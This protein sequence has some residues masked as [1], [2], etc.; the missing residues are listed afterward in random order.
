MTSGDQSAEG[1]RSLF[2]L[3]PG[4]RD[5]LIQIAQSLGWRAIGARRAKDA[6]QRYLHSEAQIAL[7]DLRGGGDVGNLLAPLVPAME[8]GGG[9]ILILIDERHLD[10]VPALL[11]V[12]ATHY[13]AG[14]V[15]DL[16]LNAALTSAH[17]LVE[18]LGGG[19]AH[20]QRAQRIRRGDAL[21]WALGHDGLL[22][23]SDSLAQHL[24]VDAARIAPAAL[25]RRLP[26]VERRT[27]LA[28][29]R[30]M[31]LSGRPAVLAH[32]LPA[33]P[34]QRLVHHLREADGAIAADVEWLSDG[35][36]QDGGSRDHLTGLRSRQA[37]LDWLDRRAG[38][39]TT[40]LL[41]SISQFDRMN[42]A[43]GQVVGDALLGRIARRI[44]RMVDDVAPGTMV[45]RIAGTEF[46]VGL[47][48]EVAGSDRATFLAR[49]LIGAVGQPFSAGDH[50]IRL[51]ARC[52]IAQA[53]AEDDVTQLLR[54]AG[55][56][57]SDARQAG[58]EG[59][60]ILSAE[61]QSRQVDADRLETDLRLA[62]D[63]GEI[64]IVFQPQYPVD[65]DKISGV[66]AL[67]RW[68][69]AHY[70]PLG[71]GILF[72]T[73]ERSDY[74]LPLSAHIQAEALRQAAAWP[75]ALAELRLS[76]NVTAAD[77]AQP[78]FMVDFLGLVDR[79][80]FPRSRLTVEITESGL[81]EDVG[82]A[83]AL[84][85]AL[86]AEGLGVAIDD[87]GTGY[88]SLAYLKNLPLD[89]LK[90]D[91]GLAQDIA[92]TA[93]DRIIVR[94][95]IHMA[96]SLGLKVI[97]EGVET[98]EQLALLSREGCDYYQGFLRSAGVSSA[99]LI[100]LVLAG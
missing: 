99:D 98:E 54:R 18:R 15:T 27:L 92:G 90:I 26:R 100:N 87:F 52:G 76:I 6:P 37:A 75:R 95:V 42:A 21:Y 34:G 32:G 56:A 46:L 88:S 2:I 23:L 71:A 70:G 63:R 62:L 74:M 20:N 19:V 94:G 4:D 79:S 57:L 31:R 49:Q 12:G 78:G 24:G 84:L 13:L 45:A 43:Y 1:Q 64:S 22:R 96:K 16:R 60:R 80:G 41:L 73:A 33:R 14:P 51:I 3:S 67:A 44:E 89:Y 86:R 58:G 82:A 97:A 25:V 83:S 30:M 81:I 69:H 85:T 65:S 36:A 29:L 93:R 8:A 9:A 39:P 17:R 66:E 59:I 35:Q 77:I 61:K 38:L 7:V 28:A 47:T 53:R 5:G 50:L 72:A 55:T 68:N 11:A 10:Q 91:S 40:I 48:G